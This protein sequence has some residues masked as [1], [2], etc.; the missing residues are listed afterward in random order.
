MS[1]IQRVSAGVA[2]CLSDDALARMGPE[3][4]KR[5]ETE[6][7]TKIESAGMDWTFERDESRRELRIIPTRREES[8]HEQ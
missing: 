2:I 6:V 1:D 8:L 3:A 4:A 7:K 5:L